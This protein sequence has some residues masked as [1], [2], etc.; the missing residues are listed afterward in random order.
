[1]RCAPWLSQHS[2]RLMKALGHA[3]QGLRMIGKE[4]GFE[5]Q[6]GHSPYP[7]PAMED[8]HHHHNHLA[9]MMGD[10]VMSSF[11]LKN[12]MQTEH[13]RMLL[14]SECRTQTRKVIFII[15]WCLEMYSLLP[16]WTHTCRNHNRSNIWAR[17]EY[18]MKSR[19][20]RKGLDNF[21]Y[22]KLDNSYSINTFCVPQIDC[23]STV[24]VASGPD[25]GT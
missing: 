3:S 13:L 4:E 10:L 18:M 9:R 21:I 7:S 12:L 5:I 24:V 1:M 17:R 25:A 20:E 22:L 15:T 23:A 2:Q 14:R 16:A 11:S 19:K 8:S 6:E